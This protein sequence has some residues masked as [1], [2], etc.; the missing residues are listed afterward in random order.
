MG[1]PCLPLTVDAV[2]R[3]GLADQR[4]PFRPGSPAKR[5]RRRIGT[6]TPGCLTS[7]SPRKLPG[8]CGVPP[9]RRACMSS[10]GSTTSPRAM[11]C[12]QGTLPMPRPRASG[13]GCNA[14]LVDAC[15]LA[16]LLL[17]ETVREDNRV[18]PCVQ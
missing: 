3:L 11:R 7:G 1:W 12:S 6:L 9:P 15:V 16:R 13:R 17:G 2:P 14:S 8:S 5:L 10:A 18:V 4:P